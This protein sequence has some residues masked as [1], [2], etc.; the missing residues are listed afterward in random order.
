[1]ARP[2]HPNAFSSHSR[3]VNS[4]PIAPQ[5]PAR[6]Q[7]YHEVRRAYRTFGTT[8]ML[9]SVGSFVLYVL[10]SCFT[11]ALMDIQVAGHVT[12]GLIGGLSQFVVMATTARLY[13]VHMRTR[14]DPI[15][16]RFRSE[17]DQRAEQQRQNTAPSPEEFRAW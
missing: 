3:R 7:D 13:A 11:P 14:V 6:D 9:L 2:T 8:A 5:K 1:M 17:E 15:V 10:L 12:L 16:D 4:R